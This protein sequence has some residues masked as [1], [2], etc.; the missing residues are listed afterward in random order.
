MFKSITLFERVTLL[1]SHE[2]NE[3]KYDTMSVV[4]G[5]DFDSLDRLDSAL[6]STN[7][8]IRPAIVAI[9]SPITAIQPLSEAI[10]PQ[11]SAIHPLASANNIQ[12]ETGPQQGL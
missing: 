9:Q 5:N 3:R 10:Q 8:A 6:D 12:A 1:E 11:I 4:A 2:A 7:E